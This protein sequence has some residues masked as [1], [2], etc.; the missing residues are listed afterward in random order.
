MAQSLRADHEEEESMPRV[1]LLSRRQVAELLSVSDRTVR[2]L[3]E[4]GD[5]SA[6]VRIGRAARWHE[7]GVLDYVRQLSQGQQD[8]SKKSRPLEQV[9][10]EGRAIVTQLSQPNQ[11]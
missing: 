11:L 2:R 4:R 9:E 10:P 7:S 3:A 5:L 8:S 1:K 6:P